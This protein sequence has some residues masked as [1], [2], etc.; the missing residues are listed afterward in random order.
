MSAAE[1]V[2]L[3][4]IR[5]LFLFPPEPGMSQFPQQPQPPRHLQPPPKS[6][7]SGGAIALLVGGISLVVLLIIGLLLLAILLP[8][9]GAA[10]RTAKRMQNS[11]QLR[12]IHQGLVTHA[13]SNRG[14]FAGLNSKGEVMLNSPTDTGNSGDGDTVEARYWILLEG[15][16]FTP[17]YAISPSETDPSVFAYNSGP[18][19]Q[20]APVVWDSTMRHY[21][22]AML[23]IDGTP[24]QVVADSQTPHR[25][26]EWNQTLNLQAVVMGDRNTGSNATSGVSSFH[27]N[28]SGE[29]KGTVLWND[30]H[31][32]FE[33]T[34]ILQTRYGNGPANSQDNLF[35]ASGDTDAY[36]IHQGD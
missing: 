27:S 22:Y 10:R 11:T 3:L 9:L 33:Q 8:A 6:G 13:N 21:S 14:H 32:A 7:M 5:F 18:S 1:A 19:V 16:Y 24:G 23:S 36:L 15:S 12:G 25:V 26:H 30:N 35:S 29:W 17:D 31:V 2:A 4:L 20:S 28:R 34:H